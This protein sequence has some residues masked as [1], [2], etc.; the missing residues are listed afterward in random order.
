MIRL[1]F[2]RLLIFCAA[3][4]LLNGLGFMYAHLARQAQQAQNPYGSRQDGLQAPWSAYADYVGGLMQG[5]MG[6][7]PRGYGTDVAG[8]IWK[9]AG[10]SLGLLGLSFIISVTAGLGLGLASARLNPPR[11]SAWFSPLMTLGLAL[12]G[13][14]IASLLI[15]LFLLISM[16][17]DQKPLLPLWG[18][19]W[20]A[21][22]ILP[23]LAL[24]IRPAMQ[25]AQMTANLMADELKTQHIVTARAI[26]NTWR[27]IRWKHALKNILGTVILTIAGAL[28]VTLV[29]LLV[30]EFI[31]S[32]PGLGS[33]M[34][35]LL[36]P[37][38][39]AISSAA[40]PTLTGAASIFLNPPLMAAL[41]MIFG[42]FFVAVDLLAGLLVH[43][44]DPRQREGEQHV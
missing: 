19:G 2:R 10:N 42:G 13:F 14:Y 36:V 11:V 3:L 21:H 16:R 37:P 4:V 31:F 30:V 39:V 35:S 18:M 1:I 41:L 34:V 33:L 29:E 9:A 7:M 38:R 23:V 17:T 28:R 40:A 43:Q 32:W 20:D 24:S 5:Q 44:V 8:A 6:E 27:T 15:A 12:P 26:G 22:L 25:I